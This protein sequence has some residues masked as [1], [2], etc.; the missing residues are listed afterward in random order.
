MVNESQF[1]TRESVQ[2]LQ[3]DDEVLLGVLGHEHGLARLVGPGAAAVE[4][5]QR[6]MDF[7]NVHNG[8]KL[9]RSP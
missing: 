9:S 7:V 8:K 3:G 1:L 4:H 6:D 2:H 5:L